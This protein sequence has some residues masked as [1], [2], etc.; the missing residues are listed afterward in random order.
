[1]QH[2]PFIIPYIQLIP[3]ADKKKKKISSF[4]SLFSPLFL[5]PTPFISP[6]QHHKIHRKNFLSIEYILFHSISFHS[7]PPLDL[8]NRYT[9]PKQAK[10]QINITTLLSLSPFLPFS[11][12]PPSSLLPPPSSLPSYLKT[13]QF[14]FQFYIKPQLQIKYYSPLSS[15]FAS[16]IIYICTYIHTSLYRL[17]RSRIYSYYYLSRPVSCSQ[18]NEINLYTCTPHI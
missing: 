5:L 8:C 16:S 10:K 4:F 17:N 14:Q 7:I 12:S 1:M 6:S 15:E 11:L 2:S 9:H 13:F 3:S 18:I